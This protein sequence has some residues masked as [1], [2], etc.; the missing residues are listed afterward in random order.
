MLPKKYDLRTHSSG[1]FGD[2][3]APDKELRSEASLIQA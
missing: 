1:G 2:R 3:A